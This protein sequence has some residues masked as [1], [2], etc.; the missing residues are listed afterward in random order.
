MP[1]ADKPSTDQPPRDRREQEDERMRRRDTDRTLSDRPAD[2][3]RAGAKVR[4]PP[5]V[6]AE[7][8]RDPGRQ[9][10]GAPPVDNRS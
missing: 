5:G 9:T 3:N 8:V 10:P 2:P 4:I 7:D 6:D 1:N